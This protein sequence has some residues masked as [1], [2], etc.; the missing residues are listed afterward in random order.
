MKSIKLWCLFQKMFSNNVQKPSIPLINVVFPLQLILI[1]LRSH[2]I[3]S[4]NYFSLAQKAWV[5]NGNIG[6]QMYKMLH[7]SAAIFII[8]YLE[9]LSVAIISIW[10]FKRHWN[11]R[12]SAGS[13]HRTGTHIH[14]FMDGQ[15]F[16]SNLKILAIFQNRFQRIKYYNFILVDGLMRIDFKYT[17]TYIILIYGTFM[18]SF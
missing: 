3:F 11:F 6:V 14:I 9:H 7:I 5:F 18:L 2:F 1:I 17:H 16:L 10:I 13:I 12:N 15:V 8:W 4:S